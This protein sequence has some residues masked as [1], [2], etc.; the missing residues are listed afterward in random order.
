MKR[1]R[2]GA[3]ADVIRGGDIR[4]QQE[5]VE[6]LGAQGHKVT[7]ATVSRDITE[8]GLVKVAREGRSVYALPTSEEAAEQSGQHRLSELLRDLPID[9][10]DSGLMLVVRAV[11]GTAHAIATA[12]DRAGWVDVLGTIAGDDTL[13][14]ATADADALG[15]VR[16]RLLTLGR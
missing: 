1:A 14:I 2:H 8:M 10:R 15:R 5:I 6:A 9:V 7:Q 16:E 12:L 3:I 4:T 13:F 11:P